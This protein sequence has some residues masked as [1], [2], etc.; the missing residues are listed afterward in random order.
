MQS[1]LTELLEMHGE[2]NII[3]TAGSE[4]DATAW[5][6][7]H[8]GA[9]DIVT[10]DLTLR[11]GNGFN[12]VKRFRNQKSSGAVVVLSDFVTP[13]VQKRCLELGAHAAFSK[14]DVQAFMDFLRG[15]HAP[16]SIEG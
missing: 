1:V 11:E 3:G 13:V 7:V 2:F 5:L 14:D 8:E 4:T 16:S 10:I 9:W 12:L 15:L 6:L